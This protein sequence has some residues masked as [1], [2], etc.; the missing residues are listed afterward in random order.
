MQ[1]WSRERTTILLYTY[2]AY[3]VLMSN[4]RLHIQSGLLF[5]AFL[6]RLLWAF[7]SSYA[8]YVSCLSH[9]HWFDDPL[10]TTI[11]DD[12]HH[13]LLLLRC[14]HTPPQLPI[15]FSY[16]GAHI[17]LGNFISPSPTLVHTYT[18]ATSYQNRCTSPTVH[19]QKG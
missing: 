16:S 7:I 12:L 14:T 11:H 1:Q 17:H 9:T 10:N 4:L 2:V 8:C 19:P 5:P 3:L 18:W 13:H 6:T 15:T